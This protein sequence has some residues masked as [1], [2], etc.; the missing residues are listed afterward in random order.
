MA[1]T[2]IFFLWIWIS[3]DVMM[4]V[5][6]RVYRNQVVYHDHLFKSFLTIANSKMYLTSF[7]YYFNKWGWF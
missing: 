6:N 7:Y 5:L 3:E 4:L 1:L 2:R